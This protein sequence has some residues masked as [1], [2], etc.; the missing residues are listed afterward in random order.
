MHHGI[1][2][3]DPFLDRLPVQSIVQCL[4][5]KEGTDDFYTL[6]ILTMSQNL[7]DESQEERQGKMLLHT[8]YSLLD[9]LS[10]QDGIVHHH[11]IF[12]VNVL[13]AK[14]ASATWDL[15]Y[16]VVCKAKLANHKLLFIYIGQSHGRKIQQFRAIRIHW[17]ETDANHSS[18][19]LPRST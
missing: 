6:K 2:F 15:L 17:A 4:S 13:S 3:Q 18:I 8:E 9:L 12:K 7:L 10:T 16:H 11:G 19:G 1:I 14:Y 5:R